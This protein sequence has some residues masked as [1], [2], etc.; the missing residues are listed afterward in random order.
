MLIVVSFAAV[1]VLVRQPHEA[2][3]FAGVTWQMDCEAQGSP[4]PSVFWAREG[5]Q[6]LMFPGQTYGRIHVHENGTLVI[7]PVTREDAGYFVCSALS[8][9][10]STTARALLQVNKSSFPFITTLY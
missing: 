2:N 8:E 1:P 3:V 9:V 5:T 10:G 7:S 6:L 4:V